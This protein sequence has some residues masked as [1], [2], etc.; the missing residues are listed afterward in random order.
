[1][2]RN[3][4]YKLL[5]ISHNINCID[6][7]ND[8]LNFIDT[9]IVKTN[10]YKDALNLLEE[11]PASIIVISSDSNQKED[12]EFIEKVRENIFFQDKPIIMLV[13]SLKY[14]FKIPGVTTF[15]VKPI[16]KDR[17]SST[18]I[19]S[20]EKY[21][22]Q[23]ILIEELFSKTKK[24]KEELN[25]MKDRMLLIFTH[26]LK[27]PLNAI[28]NFA[29][30]INR[31]LKKPLSRK[32]VNRYIELSEIIKINGEVLSNE[33]NTLLDI[34]KIKENRMVFN[35]EKISLDEI[36]SHLVHNYKLLYS[37]KVQSNIE[38]IE[39]IGDKKS[40]IH[41]F[42]NIYSN[43][44]KYSR[45]EV[46]ISLKEDENNFYLE[47]EDDGD[48]IKESQREKIFE[49]FEQTEETTLTRE[50]EGTGIG[51]YIVKLLCTHFDYNIEITT[52]V[53]GGAKFCII[54]S[55]G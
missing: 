54:G 6:M 4:K 36:I 28:I 46:K 35:T 24:H 41:I 48:G 5:F 19:E 31:G 2:S 42:E 13:E 32:K 39:I 12:I 9:E 29:D 55:K 49:I 20:I 17:L 11:D 47:V 40:I 43:A 50:K 53:L 27:T 21:Y 1:M 22:E 15:L 44:L 23:N 26:E 16:D 38:T 14:S 8:K 34:S 52:S 37:K 18:I 10:N 25:L 33:I 45:T 51:L 30:H 7:I 3:I